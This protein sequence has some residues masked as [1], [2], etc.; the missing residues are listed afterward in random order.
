MGF[1][2]LVVSLSKLVCD[3]NWVKNYLYLLY[4]V[5]AFIVTFSNILML[6]KSYEESHCRSN[7]VRLNYTDGFNLCAF[8]SLAYTYGIFGLTVCYYVQ[9]LDICLRVVFNYKATK[10]LHRTYFTAV[11]VLPAIPTI[12]VYAKNLYGSRQGHYSCWFSDYAAEKPFGIFQI[13]LPIAIFTCLGLINFILVCVKVTNVLRQSMILRVQDEQV[14]LASRQKA[15]LTYFTI[16]FFLVMTFLIVW[17]AIILTSTFES[18]N[19]KKYDES[20]NAWT[21]CVFKNFDELKRNAWQSRCGVHP[22]HRTPY[23]LRVFTFFIGSCSTAIICSIYLF[24]VPNQT[25]SIQKASRVSKRLYNWIRNTCIFLGTCLVDVNEA[26][27]FGVSLVNSELIDDPRHR[28]RSS[29]P[30]LNALRHFSRD[31]QMYIQGRSNDQYR[32]NE[33]GSSIARSKGFFSFGPTRA[34]LYGQTPSEPIEV[35]DSA[36]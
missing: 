12:I 31:F 32:S 36:L 25:S 34:W 35:V 17:C 21:E 5:M 28:N 19:H 15:I 20:Y 16:P 1:C 23:P 4:G 8:Q 29:M 3:G 22:E 6:G 10:F 14:A 13:Y 9:S 27:I 30:N 7:A 33:N 18:F 26:R 24:I 2:M 11:V